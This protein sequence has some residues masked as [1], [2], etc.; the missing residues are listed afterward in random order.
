MVKSVSEKWQTSLKLI[1]VASEDQLA[2]IDTASLLFL[3]Q[4]IQPDAQFLFRK[5]TDLS[6]II[7]N[8]TSSAS[9]VDA[10]A[11]ISTSNDPFSVIHGMPDLEQLELRFHESVKRVDHFS[12]SLPKLQKIRL[13]FDDLVEF[14]PTAFDHLDGLDKLAIGKYKKEKLEKF[15]TGLAPRYIQC[16]GVKLLKLNTVNVTKIKIIETWGMVESRL[17]LSELEELF[18]K[19]D[20]T[21][22]LP[23][24][25]LQFTGLCVL[26]LT[27]TDLSQIDRGQLSCLSKLKI[28]RLNPSS[29]GNISTSIFN[30]MFA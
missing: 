20:N 1:R 30:E 24:F 12:P 15:E 16:D 9:Q 25:F 26:S 13:Y 10:V 3:F 2:V 27:L 11:A 28:L 8:P 17:P 29:Y 6:I 14:D 23:I 18:F 21:I 7:H 4:A 22:Q 19:P 5:T